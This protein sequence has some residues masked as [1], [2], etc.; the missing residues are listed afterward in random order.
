MVQ[1]ITRSDRELLDAQA[2][3][4]E[5]VPP[6]SVFAFLAEHRHELFPD[7]FI[8]DLFRSST[9]RPSLPADLIG[10]VLV[11]KELYDLSDPQTA[12]ALRYDIRWKVAC[13]RAL[14]QTSFDPSTLVYWRKRIAASARPDRVF[15]AVARV[16]AETGILRGRRKRCVDSTVFDD[17]VATQDTVI[18]LVAAMRKVARCVPGAQAVIAQVARRD[19]SKPG[20]PDIDWDD[21]QAKQNLVSDLVN[22]ALAVLAELTGEDA[23]QRE[24]PAADAVGLL[25]L[26]AGQDV[27]PAEGSDGTDGR[28]RIARR[29]APDRMISTVDPEARHTRKSKSTR[30]DGFRG[31]VSAE[32]DTGLITDAELTMASGEE[33]SDAVVGEKMIARDR[34]HQ[35]GTASG[36]ADPVAPTDS[37]PADAGVADQVIADHGAAGS[38]TTGSTQPGE[39]STCS[40]GA[41]ADVGVEHADGG[42]GAEQRPGL[43]VYGDSAYGTGKA[44][45]AYV[46]AGH[47]TVIKPKPLQPA[48]P[49]GFTLDDFAIDEQ[50][51]T[52][53]CPGGHTRAM[54]PK[55]TVTFARVCMDCPLRSRCTTARD[56]RSMTIHEHEQLLRAA[57]A[58]ART[59]EFQQTYPTRSVVERIIAWTATS[60]G[61]RIKLRYLGVDKNHSWLRTRCAAINLRTLVGNGLT[62]IDGAWALA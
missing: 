39:Q 1:G 52:V 54:S 20:K 40:V 13:G 35:P 55:R 46:E 8:A 51:A 32:P 45:A 21:A 33:G 49:G 19:Y 30:R 34:Y 59:P 27:E 36:G 4:G 44:R 9:G 12:E 10:S 56:G 26:V 37:D 50:A 11:L 41:V 17:A 24:G 23:P 14:T 5:L 15:D 38:D 47:D 42:A 3:V 28:W 48:V 16:I 25:A 6:G 53:T 31:H 43:Q 60:R 18:Q 58:Q 57:R 29:V 7:S 62:R 2:L 61:R 22:D